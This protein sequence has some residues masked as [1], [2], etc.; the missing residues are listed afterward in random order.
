[1]KSFIKK[2]PTGVKEE[3]EDF[4]LEITYNKLEEDIK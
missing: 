3:E 4:K 2:T 1:L